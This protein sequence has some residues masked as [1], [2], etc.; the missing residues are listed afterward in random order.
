M[1]K[2][3]ALLD[4]SAYSESVCHHTAWIAKK[5]NAGVDAMHVLGR[6]EGA[7][8]TD[9]SGALGFGARSA[10]LK[11]LSSLDE[12]RAKLAQAKGHAILE[13]AKTILKQD[14]V[15]P[16][17]LKLRKG[18][19]LEAVREVENDIRAIT[20]GKR[21]E[22]SDFASG[23]LGSNLERIVRTSKV[24]VFVASREFR[25]ISKVLVA[26]DGSASAKVAIER[27]STSPVFKDLDICVLCIGQDEARA[28][29][30]AEEAVAKLHDADI[31]A[32]PRSAAGEPE[33]V[34]GKLISEDGFD[35]LVMGAYGPSRIRHLIIGSTTTAMIQTVRIPVLLYR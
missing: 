31:T 2:I 9:L 14:G 35:L 23:H 5:L 8:P 24:P 30:I 25:T 21:G 6:R 29:K 18:D 33:E 4:G 27:M 32:I 13:D 22:G 15:Q 28:Q 16:V 12:Q 34:L 1:D 19:L 17:N 11:E 10:L 3:L 26:Y 20:I 7:A